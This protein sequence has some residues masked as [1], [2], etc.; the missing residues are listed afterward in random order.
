VDPSDEALVRAF[1]NGDDRAF[2]ALYDPITSRT[3]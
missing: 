1:R 3:A 2:E